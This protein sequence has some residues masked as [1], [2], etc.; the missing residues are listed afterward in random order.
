M[1]TSFRP[2]LKFVENP[3]NGRISG[4]HSRGGCGPI[5]L[6]GHHIMLCG[7]VRPPSRES[8]G[9]RHRG[10]SQGRPEAALMCL[11]LLRL[12]S[13]ARNPHVDGPTKIE[14]LLMLENANIPKDLNNFYI[15]YVCVSS[16]LMEKLSRLQ[17]AD[18]LDMVALIRIPSTFRNVL[19][20]LQ[21]ED[22]HAWFPFPHR[23]L[24]L[25]E[26]QVIL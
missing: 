18:F 11:D 26:I 24:V 20:N 6:C 12:P 8:G 13:C 2:G 7:G 25:D 5:G 19:D 22:C 4:L 21:E 23:I 15:R 9:A 3:V 1:K 10:W 14:C 16:M 17:S